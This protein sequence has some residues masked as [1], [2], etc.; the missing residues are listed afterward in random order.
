MELTATAEWLTETF[1]AFDRAILAFLHALAESCGVV[2]T[3]AMKLVSLTAKGGIML[4]IAAAVMMLFRKTR[5]TGICALLAIAVGAV[6]TN[7]TIKN[8]VA[9]P[10][11]YDLL[12]EYRVWWQ[13]VN[14]VIEGEIYSFPSGHATATTAFCT[15]L[16]LTRG[17]RYVPWCVLYVAVMGMSRCY[18]VVHYPSDILGG[19]ITG[20]AAGCV[21]WLITRALYGKYG[22][23]IDEY[24]LQLRSRRQK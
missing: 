12:E 17:K 20:A 8:A 1:S 19:I 6:F 14:G 23:R 22:G 18:L 5:K 15:A 24:T 13:Y 3:P 16:A 4:I 10:R 7:L 2:L 11:P 9:R 21:S